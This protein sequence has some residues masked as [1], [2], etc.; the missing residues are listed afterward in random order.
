MSNFPT[1]LIYIYFKPEICEQQLKTQDF[2]A[3]LLFGVKK[4]RPVLNINACK[5]TGI[6]LCLLFSLWILKTFYYIAVL[7][8][9]LGM[10]YHS[11][12][13]TLRPSP[14]FRGFSKITCYKDKE[15]R[16]SIISNLPKEFVTFMSLCLTET[17]LSYR[18]TDS[19]IPNSLFQLWFN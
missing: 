19:K 10:K 5:I 7:S 11:H 18:L 9:L 15:C 12:F 13:S 17:K 16:V 8:S 4:Q 1:Q 2:R 3:P 6:F 14:D